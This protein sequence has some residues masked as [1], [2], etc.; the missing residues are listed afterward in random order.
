D[1]TGAVSAAPWGSAGVLPISWMY[2]AMLGPEGL[3]RSTEVAVLNANYLATALKD[4][5]PVLYTGPGGL[6]AHECIV[7]I[8]QIERDTGVTNEDIAKRLIDFGFHAPT[9]SFP[10]AGTLMVE[11]T[12]SESKFEMDRFIDAMIA[13]KTEVDAV[14]E[15]VAGSVLR[16]AP[17]TAEDLVSD[18]WDRSYSREEAAYPVESLRTHKY[19]VPVGRVDNA[20]GDRHVFCECPPIEDYQ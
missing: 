5:Y 9:M 7:D 13:I 2:V 11:P 16:N 3:R 1:G 12:E 14:G 6:V 4:H 19:W 10:V 15:D 18:T 20:Y 8:R 17:H